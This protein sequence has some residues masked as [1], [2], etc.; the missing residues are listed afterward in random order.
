MRIVFTA[1]KK[2]IMKKM[3]LK[4]EWK[5]MGKGEKKKRFHQ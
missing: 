4:K 5:L 2:K 3:N 1:T